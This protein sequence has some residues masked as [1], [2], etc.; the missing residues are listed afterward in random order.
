MT[1]TQY[2]LLVAYIRVW[3]VELESY[4]LEEAVADVGLTLSVEEAMHELWKC[5]WNWDGE[6]LTLEYEGDE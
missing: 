1:P 2:R 6:T 3:V 4:T 5:G